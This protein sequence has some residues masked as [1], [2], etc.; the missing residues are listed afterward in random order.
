[1]KKMEECLHCANGKEAGGYSTAE[2][3]KKTAQISVEE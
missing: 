2:A 1:M 3:E